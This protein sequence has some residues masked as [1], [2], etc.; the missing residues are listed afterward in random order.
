[1]AFY[2][3][4]SQA[5]RSSQQHTYNDKLKGDGSNLASVLMK[6]IG[7]HSIKALRQKDEASAF[8][9][10]IHY[11]AKIVPGIES[12]HVSSEGAINRLVFRQPLN[13]ESE[14]YDDR[15]FYA[16]SMSEGTLRAFAILVALFQEKDSSSSELSLIGI[17]EPETSIH[18]VDMALARKRSDFF[19]KCYRDI[20]RPLE[21][22]INS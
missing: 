14:D 5:L 3:F 13:K 9:R 16:S 20:Q 22:L 6:L 19:D 8:N 4:N 18:P 2:H 7:K 15:E 12:V 10:S 17:E 1:M 21:E 11:L